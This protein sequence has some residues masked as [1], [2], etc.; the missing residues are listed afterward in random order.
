MIGK[1]PS[2]NYLDIERY[3]KTHDLL[4][5]FISSGF[6]PIMTLQTHIIYNTSTLIDHIYININVMMYL[7]TV[8][9]F[10]VD[11]LSSSVKLITINR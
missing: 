1:D 2:F 10:P 3:S 5:I 11:Y 4:Y 6:L 7:F 8:S 9:I